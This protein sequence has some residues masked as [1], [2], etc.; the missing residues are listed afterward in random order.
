MEAV[1]L[2]RSN[3]GPDSLPGDGGGPHPV[4][5]QSLPESGGAECV[6]KAPHARPQGAVALLVGRRP[7]LC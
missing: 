2:A 4:Q 3:I 5:L 7:E 6:A 1:C